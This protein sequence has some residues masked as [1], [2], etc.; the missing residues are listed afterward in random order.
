MVQTDRHTDTA[1]RQTDRPSTSRQEH[2]CTCMDKT[3]TTPPLLKWLHF[4]YCKKKKKKKG[5]GGG[6]GGKKKKKEEEEICNKHC[7]TQKE[8][9]CKFPSLSSR[10]MKMINN[11]D[12]GGVGDVD[13][14][15]NA[16]LLQKLFGYS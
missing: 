3:T 5:G 7:K 2:V 6:G 16:L 15:E 11:E 14:D 9:F 8:A 12:D 10:L 4:Q 13:D 1:D